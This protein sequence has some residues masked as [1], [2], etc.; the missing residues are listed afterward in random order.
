MLKER[1]KKGI[2][3]NYKTSYKLLNH[4]KSLIYLNNQSLKFPWSQF[5]NAKS[6]CWSYNRIQCLGDEAKLI[7]AIN[8]ALISYLCAY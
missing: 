3:E 1:T 4:P 2:V 5:I 7:Q 8:N 6:S